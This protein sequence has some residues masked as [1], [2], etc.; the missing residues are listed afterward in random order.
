MFDAELK[1]VDEEGKPILLTTAVAVQQRTR[2]AAFW[3]QALR[4][5]RFYDLH[6]E[7]AH[8]YERESVN[9]MEK[10]KKLVHEYRAMLAE[11][12]THRYGHRLVPESRLSAAQAQ[13]AAGD[14]E[15]E[16]ED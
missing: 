7:L 2:R 6:D 8:C 5:H 1:E 10:C 14:E 16:E 9:H 4:G 15:G 11:V 3:E 12:Q 13:A